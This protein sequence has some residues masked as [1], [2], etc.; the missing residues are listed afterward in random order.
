MLRYKV[1]G[2]WLRVLRF[3]PPSGA[4]RGCL[5]GERGDLATGVLTVEAGAS[6]VGEGAGAQECRRPPGLEGLPRGPR[7][8]DLCLDNSLD[9]DL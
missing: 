6:G 8:P 5:W 9:I 1:K 3:G 7:P 4:S 2:L